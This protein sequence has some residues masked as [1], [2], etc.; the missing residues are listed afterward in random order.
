MK[1][2][3]IFPFNYVTGSQ[4]AKYDDSDMPITEISSTLD[5]QKL[6]QVSSST[7]IQREL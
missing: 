1:L 2:D 5:R 4:E 3:D 6:Y 7:R